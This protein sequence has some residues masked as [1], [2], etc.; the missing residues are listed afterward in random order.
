MFMLE[1]IRVFVILLAILDPFMATP[2]FLA[3][4]KKMKEEERNKII[5]EAVSVAGGIM[6]IFLLF[7]INILQIFGITLSSLKVA[8]GL[9]IFIVGLQ[10][11]LGYEIIKEKDKEK[12]KT[13]IV[14][15]LGTP[16]LAGPAAITTIIIVS[17]DYGFLVSLIGLFFALL[18]TYCVMRM[19]SII[20]KKLGGRGIE[21][22][23]R[24]MGLILAAFAIEFIKSGVLQIVS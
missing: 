22:V 21:L 19:G 17:Q 9:I 15:L 18:A 16:I 14:L 20:V 2:P 5:I 12:K 11:T 4:T 7:G 8:G 3:M 24:V 1:F 23:S 10:L 13:A 6:L